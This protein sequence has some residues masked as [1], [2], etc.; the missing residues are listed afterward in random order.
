MKTY[1]F[2]IGANVHCHDGQCGKLTKVVVNPNTFEVTNLVVEEGFLLKHARAF[3]V[4]LV[5]K[6]AGDDIYFALHSDQLSKYPEYVETE[7]ERPESGWEGKASYQPGDVLF[8]SATA[9]YDMGVRMV[10][11]KVRQGI[12]EE[13]AV[14]EKGTKV[15][16]DEDVIGKLDHVISD[17]E[18]NT[19]SHL[20]IRQG[21]LFP[22]QL[23][24]P[25]SLIKSVSEEGIFVTATNEVL[26]QYL[27]SSDYDEGDETILT[28][29]KNMS[30]DTVLSGASELASKI[31]TAL[32][33]DDRFDDDTAIEVINES[34]IITLTGEVDS[35]EKREA[36]AEI[37]ASYPDVISVTNSLKVVN[38]N[39]DV[40]VNE[41]VVVVPP[42]NQV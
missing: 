4:S 39:D 21:V 19:I 10:K 29:E 6:A 26:A 20:V 17:Q 1:N 2:N 11:E 15:Y 38:P 25:I 28:K 22:D 16:N 7:Y 18:S 30:N 14:V 33:E 42:V 3:P 37:A 35:Q 9:P 13:L 12:A 40:A 24:I 8:P 32:F 31:S 36:A 34:G 41:E 5:E 23:E 27:P